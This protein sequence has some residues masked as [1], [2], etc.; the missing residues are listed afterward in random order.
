MRNWN[1]L[2]T[3]CIPLLLASCHTSSVLQTAKTLNKGEAEFTASAAVYA[4]SDVLPGFNL[5]YRRGI[6]EKM[7]FGI[8]YAGTLYGHIRS[9]L[10]IN[11]WKNANENIFL[12]SGVGLDF[13]LLNDWGSDIPPN[14]G[15][16]VP[17]YFSFNHNNN[18]VP[19]FCQSFTFSFH[20][21][22]IIPKFGQSNL[23][24]SMSL[25]H[26][27]FQRGGFGIRFGRGKRVRWM[28]EVSHNIIYE[29][30]LSVFN[31]HTDRSFNVDFLPE[32]NAGLVFTFK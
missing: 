8:A 21:V 7:D 11:L 26:Y 1:Y 24:E 19:Y 14:F 31:N 29:H 17:L 3:C 15:I 22:A 28:V 13:H 4:A 27:M 16:T 32:L 5:M 6:N 9:D 18:V 20:D 12:S 10:K 23:T 2:L 25:G 30:R